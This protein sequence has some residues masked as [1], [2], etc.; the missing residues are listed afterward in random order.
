MCVHIKITL[1]ISIKRGNIYSKYG[2]KVVRM[3]LEIDFNEN[4][5]TKET[6]CHSPEQL[7]I[8]LSQNVTRNLTCVTKHTLTH[9]FP[10][11]SIVEDE[12]LRKD[13]ANV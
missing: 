8:I 7:R 4:Y 11:F 10:Q 2:I 13:R 6:K 3:S 5:S 1:F 12:P 9:D